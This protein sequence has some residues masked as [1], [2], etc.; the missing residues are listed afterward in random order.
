MHK[1]EYP[2]IPFT[3]RLREDNLPI[4]VLISGMEENSNLNDNEEQVTGK[5]HQHLW[6]QF[7]PHTVPKRQ[8]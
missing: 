5:V 2:D 3:L 6:I 8:T 7:M 1:I 4:S